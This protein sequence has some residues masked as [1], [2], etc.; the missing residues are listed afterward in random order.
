[1]KSSDS[2]P[3]T[4]PTH[5]SF[6]HINKNNT[7]G[8]R[9]QAQQGAMKRPAM[10]AKPQRLSNGSNTTETGERSRAWSFQSFDAMVGAEGRMRA[11]VGSGASSFDEGVPFHNFPQPTLASWQRRSEMV[12]WVRSSAPGPNE[13]FE[14]LP[15][16]VLRLIL[17]HLRRLHVEKRASS[18]ATCWMRDCC[19]ISMGNKKW[20]HAARAALYE[21]IQLVGSDSVQQRKKYKVVYATRLVLLRRSLRAD[22]RLAEMVRSIKVPALP[23]DA[24]IEAGAYHDIVAS[25]VKACPNLERLDGFYPSYNHGDSR[26]F[27]ALTSKDKLK[28]MT[29]VIDALSSDFG[30]HGHKSHAS[31]SKNRLS[32]ADSFSKLH[33]N[34]Y[35][36]LT[37][38]LANKFVRHHMNWNDLSHLTIHCLPGANLR[39]PNGLINIVLTYLPSLQS[40]Y[41]SHIPAESFDDSHLLDLPRRLKKLSISHC[42][43][44]TA[45]GLSTFATHSAAQDL[46]TLTLIHQN[47]DSLP[48]IVR[49]FSNLH[50][51]TTFNL[52][53]SLAPALP[54]DT[55]A[56]WLMPYLASGSLR[57]L[58]WDIFESESYGVTR[59][60]DVLA[61]SI[62]ANGF[63]SL[64][65]LR[66]PCDPDGLFQALCKP[67]ERVDLPG[68]RY[69][70]HGSSLS[71]QIA[72]ST[73]PNAGGKASGVQKPPPSSN[74]YNVGGVD[75]MVATEF[76]S[77]SRSSSDTNSKDSGKFVSA[78][79]R[80]A[81]SDLHAARRAAQARLEAARQF[82][83]IEANVTDEDGILIESSGL[84]GYIGTVSSNVNYSLAP[85]AGGSDDRGGLVG[86]WDLLG[87]GDEDLFASGSRSANEA[88]Y[89]TGC[90]PACVQARERDAAA[91]W[92]GKGHKLSKSSGGG[93]NTSRDREDGD[94]AAKRKVRDGCTGR[95]NSYNHE[96]FTM[97]R[98]QAGGEGWQHTERGRWR[99]RVELS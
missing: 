80:V 15:N 8:K 21:D 43:G 39:T 40:V 42:S 37:A 55:F 44:V 84:A 94:E 6:E 81:G 17:D 63:P 65:M 56:I 10:Y 54:D 49:I 70:N 82:P 26:L 2:S 75:L 99:G 61:R 83:R 67:K 7:E 4:S 51:L 95:W 23:D 86:I 88:G 62:T 87:D 77:E 96:T 16:E 76:S 18:C 71:N 3:E 69:R 98:K 13:L 24:P 48:A 78:P 68:D 41:L 5:A 60:D 22:P 91:E 92:S 45:M 85:D 47:L 30:H 90:V 28:E 59:A 32:A 52:V 53:Q 12:K 33:S 11:A 14:K 64:R 93:K 72:P 1:M 46:E 50:K 58:H 66:A 20:L 89:G 79:T 57:N 9:E 73:R 97:E 74:S 35:S 34:P 29:W 36:Y 25:V 31:R 19:S 38:Q 27:S